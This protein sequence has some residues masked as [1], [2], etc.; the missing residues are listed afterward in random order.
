MQINGSHELQ[1]K[2]LNTSTQLHL[3]ID[4]RPKYLTKY[5]KSFRGDHHGT[6]LTLDP[7]VL[8]QLC[9]SGSRS[10]NHSMSRNSLKIQWLKVR[11]MPAHRKT[12]SV[13]NT[14]NAQAA[15]TRALIWPISQVLSATKSWVKEPATWMPCFSSPL[16]SLY[17]RPVTLQESY[18]SSNTSITPLVSQAM[19]HLI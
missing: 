5:H 16:Y 6:F 11:E 1:V 12:L 15:A 4:S 17:P 10:H 18:R 3:P 9:R 13:T 7:S 14:P 8:L 2:F 19:H